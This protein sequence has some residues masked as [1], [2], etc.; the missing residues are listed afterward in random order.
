MRI[1][2]KIKLA[3]RFQKHHTNCSKRTSPNI[4]SSSLRSCQIT[5]L[6]FVYTPVV[7]DDTR[8]IKTWIWK[9]VMFWGNHAY[10]EQ[11]MLNYII[12]TMEMPGHT[13][14]YVGSRRK[15]PMWHFTTWD[16]HENK[17]TS[18]LIVAQFK[19][20][21]IVENFYSFCKCH[22]FFAASLLVGIVLRGLRSAILCL[23]A[24][25]PF[26]IL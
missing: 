22:E 24:M 2:S 8:N 10:N 1:E 23:R 15:L 9:F 20:V 25:N 12:F 4:V 5:N 16:V 11:C 14:N 18:S 17:N 13:Q 6:A 7:I 19:C 21:V 26:G 3:R